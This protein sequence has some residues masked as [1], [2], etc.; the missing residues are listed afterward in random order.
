MLGTR[1]QVGRM[2]SADE[3]TVLWRH[4]FICIDFEMTSMIT[5]SVKVGLLEQ[6]FTRFQVHHQ[7]WNLSLKS[8]TRKV[9]LMDHSA[10]CATTR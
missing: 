2:E 7:K 6:I 9:V 1:T 3:S 10:D 5:L 8:S 4:T